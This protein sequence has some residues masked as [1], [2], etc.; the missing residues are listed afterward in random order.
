MHSMSSKPTGGNLAGAVPVNVDSTP[1]LPIGAQFTI[2]GVRLLPGGSFIT[3]CKPGEE[4]LL[5]NSKK[6]SIFKL[7]MNRA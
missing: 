1:S 4:T 5:V 7:R 2:K 6:P 3:D